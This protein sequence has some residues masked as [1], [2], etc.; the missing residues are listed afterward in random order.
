V[1]E[2]L[3]RIGQRQEVVQVDA[4]HAGPAEMVGDE[5]GPKPLGQALQRAKILEIERRRRSNRHRDAVQYDRIIGADALQ[6][7][8]RAAAVDHEIFGNDF[9]P[10]DTRL[11]FE[12]ILVVDWSQ[13]KAETE[14]R[15]FLHRLLQFRSAHRHADLA[16][17]IEL[18]GAL[19]Q[20]TSQK[21][22]RS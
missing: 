2:R 8:E 7:G 13:P 16:P 10:V 5:G 1:I 9:E 4:M 11:S 22:S 17:R 14:R 21:R 18:E 20:A 6:R 12:D 15:R 3:G 19:L